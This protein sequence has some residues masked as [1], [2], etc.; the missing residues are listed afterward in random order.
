MIDEIN[1]FLRACNDLDTMDPAA[2]ASNIYK[3]NH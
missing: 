3:I 2:M 1:Q